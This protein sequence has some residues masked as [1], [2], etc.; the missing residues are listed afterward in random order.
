[1][2][3]KSWC[4]RDSQEKKGYRRSFDNPLASGAQ[5][6]FETNEYNLGWIHDFCVA[7]SFCMRVGKIYCTAVLVEK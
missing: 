2:L 5:T 1:M 7:G 4:N 6:W 3:S